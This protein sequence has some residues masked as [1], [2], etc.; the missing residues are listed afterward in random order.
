MMVGQIFSQGTSDQL[1]Y[2][3]SEPFPVFDAFQKRYFTDLGRLLMVKNNGKELSLQLYDARSLKQIGTTYLEEVSKY[4]VVEEIIKVKDQYL[5]FYS[6]WNR[7]DETEKLFYRV[8]DFETGLF[9]TDESREIIEV[10]GRL[11]GT[12]K[13]S[14]VYNFQV[15]EKFD[16]EKSS[17]GGK[18]LIKYKKKPEEDKGQPR[19]EQIGFFVFDDEVDLI[20]SKEITMNYPME[21]MFTFDY[22]MDSVGR[23]YILA[24]VFDEIFEEK[25][26][27][28]E[29]V[30]IFHYEMLVVTEGSDQLN[31]NVIGLSGYHISDLYLFNSD[32]GKIRMAGTY[33]D[34]N[35]EVNN[36]DG[37][38]VYVFDSSG[39][40]IKKKR[41]EIPLEILNMY[42]NA[43]DKKKNL[44]K[45]LEGSAE[46]K[47]L[48][49]KRLVQFEDGGLLIVGEQDFSVLKINYNSRSIGGSA[50]YEFRYNA[51]LAL[52]VDPEG[53]LLWMEKIPKKQYGTKGKG[54]MSFQYGFNKTDG[55]HYFVFMDNVKNMDLSLEEEPAQHDDGAGGYF[56]AYKLDDEDGRISKLSIFNVRDMEDLEISQFKADRV[57]QALDDAFIM[58]VYKKGKE[59]VLI[60]VDL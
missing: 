56:T 35:G 44:K 59:D 52:R 25:R 28:K 1:K 49:L 36:V 7:D 2:E 27:K 20:W 48:K 22:S 16:F 29:G 11:E 60:R 13:Q 12:R 3:V 4:F 26:W 57:I 17:D 6:I 24:R 18:L 50:Y 10:K 21:T 30:G 15:T 54:G 39:V 23:I 5:L 14:G 8:I 40:V 33:N 34:G 19:F 51:I 38:F 45:E 42:L 41:Y 58:E 55:K 31:K 9:V 37:V 32:D 43:K 46:F 47:E 53:N